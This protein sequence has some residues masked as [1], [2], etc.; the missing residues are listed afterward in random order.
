MISYRD[1]I[2]YKDYYRIYKFFQI[3]SLILPSGLL[4]EQSSQTIDLLSRKCDIILD[5]LR[6]C[7]NCKKDFDFDPLAVSGK[8]DLICPECGG[9]I[10]K[11]SRNPAIKE[12]AE[13]TEE[14]IGNIFARLMHLSYIFYM[15]MGLAGVLCYF[16]GIYTVLYAVTMI[17]VTAYLI[18][19]ITGTV[20]FASGVILLPAGAV[21]GYIFAG[22]IPGACLG[23]HIVF[24]IRHLIR[25]IIFRLVFRFIEMVSKY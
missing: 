10:G 18:Q 7:T 19:F 6:Y 17:S 5:M 9:V 14:E 16:P 21:L 11:E 12:N 15:V 23:I 25:D 2:K 22:G 1:K 3:R 8:E 4:A 13:K 20:T 24:L